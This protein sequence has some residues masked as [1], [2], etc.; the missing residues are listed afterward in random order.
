M[1]AVMSV[2]MYTEEI[3]EAHNR[4]LFLSLC[5]S[6][7]NAGLLTAFVL[8]STFEFHINL[9]IIFS[10]SL[11]FWISCFL[12]PESPIWLK[13]KGLD[14]LAFMNLKRIRAQ[15]HDFTTELNNIDKY[16]S[17]SVKLESSWLK[18]LKIFVSTRLVP[19]VIKIIR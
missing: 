16:L 10:L 2:I 4:G 3:T 14:D 11:I 13:R 18:N 6:N 12:L 8:G 7:T 5:D 15:T 9:K 17:K 1:P 19:R